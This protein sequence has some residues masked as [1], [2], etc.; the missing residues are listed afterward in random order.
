MTTPTRQVAIPLTPYPTDVGTLHFPKIRVSLQNDG[1]WTPKFTGLIDTGSSYTLAAAA[2]AAVLKIVDFK[3][4]RKLKIAGLGG[5]TTECYEHALDL[6]LGDANSG[7]TIVVQGMKVCFTQAAIPGGEDL[8][9]GQHDF[10]SRL[11]F[12]ER[13]Q[14]PRRILSLRIPP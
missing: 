7:S 8:L 10:L 11:V 2:I 13:N 4:G 3:L 6:R 5:A 14:A 1:D 12:V 9:L